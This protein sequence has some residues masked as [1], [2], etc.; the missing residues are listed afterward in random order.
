MSSLPFYFDYMASTPIALEA[1]KAMIDC[2]DE[3]FAGN[4][5]SNTHIYA[6]YANEVIDKAKTEDAVSSLHD[7]FK[8][9]NI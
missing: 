3:K 9:D 8:L 5:S 1:K 4:P 6:Y 7:A 2:L